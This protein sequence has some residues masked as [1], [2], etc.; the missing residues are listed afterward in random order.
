M[1]TRTLLLP[2]WL[3]ISEMVDRSLMVPIFEIVAIHWPIRVHFNY[4]HCCETTTKTILTDHCPSLKNWW[5]FEPI[6]ILS[7]SSHTAR[8]SWSY[9]W[10]LQTTRPQ[11]YPNEGLTI[12]GFVFQII[13]SVIYWPGSIVV[14]RIQ[15]ISLSLCL[16]L[17][18]L[19]LLLLI[20]LYENWKILWQY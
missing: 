8:L 11:E 7:R 12:R 20:D 9:F 4:K 6:S 10:S 18:F 2:A 14:L 15:I 19:V 3:W 5:S 13:K 1:V 16:T 17:S